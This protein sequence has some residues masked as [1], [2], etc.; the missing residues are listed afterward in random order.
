MF[1][2]ECCNC[3]GLDC[4][5]LA[6]QEKDDFAAYRQM[7]AANVVEFNDMSSHIIDSD[8]GETIIIDQREVEGGY[9]GEPGFSSAG[10][11]LDYI[12]G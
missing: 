4:A 7:E 6:Q 8:D 2:K 3:K 10:D 1:C 5:I 11:F 12:L 9:L